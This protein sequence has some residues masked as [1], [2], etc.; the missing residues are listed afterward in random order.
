MFLKI[1]RVNK[2]PEA[3]EL[4][5][6]PTLENITPFS[7]TSWLRFWRSRPSKESLFHP[8]Y[9]PR[10]NCPT[11]SHGTDKR[12]YHKILELREERAHRACQ[13][14]LYPEQSPGTESPSQTRQ[15]SSS[16]MSTWEL[17]NRS[18]AAWNALSVATKLLR[19][20]A[21]IT[22]RLNMRTSSHTRAL[23][24]HEKCPISL[25]PS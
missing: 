23:W 9:C 5:E 2:C 12:T 14:A 13:L 19:R 6:S 22:V 11:L 24:T 8:R 10:W 17:E 15:R 20:W 1:K 16:F 25:F 21:L 4:K 18:P 7:G 3:Q